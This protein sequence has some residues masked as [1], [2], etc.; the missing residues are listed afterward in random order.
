M[1]GEVMKLV[2]HQQDEEV[3]VAGS[4]AIVYGAGGER[5]AK[6]LWGSLL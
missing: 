4:P 5:F 3:V 2:R 1:M 6:K